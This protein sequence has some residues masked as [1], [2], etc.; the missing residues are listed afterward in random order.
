MLQRL[1]HIRNVGL[2]L[3]EEA[4]HTSDTSEVVQPSR[5]KHIKDGLDLLRVQLEASFSGD[6]SH[7][8]DG[9]H[10]Y[11]IIIQADASILTF[12]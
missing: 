9:I 3:R 1:Q 2:R 10:P 4:Y 5:W 12:D 6:L 11:L 8:R 7:E